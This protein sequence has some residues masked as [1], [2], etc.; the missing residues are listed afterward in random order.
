MEA[1]THTQA[2]EI[3]VT[4]TLV[5]CTSLAQLAEGGRRKLNLPYYLEGAGCFVFDFLRTETPRTFLEG[6]IQAGTLWIRKD[7]AIK[8][9]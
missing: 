5:R 6:H 9:S 8:L 7:N 4:E 3:T 2:D 1:T